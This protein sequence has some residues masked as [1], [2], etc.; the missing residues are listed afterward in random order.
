MNGARARQA[1]SAAGVRAARARPVRGDCTADSAGA[2]ADSYADWIGLAAQICAVAPSAVTVFDAEHRALGANERQAQPSPSRTRS[3]AFIEDLTTEPAAPTPQP[4]RLPAA[5]RVHLRLRLAAPTGETLGS[6]EILNV[7]PRRLSA[8]ARRALVAL[9]R[10]AGAWLSMQAAEDDLRTR[11]QQ[12]RAREIAGRARAKLQAALDETQRLQTLERIARSLSHELAMPLRMIA[13]GL[14][15]AE[16]ASR[17]LLDDTGRVPVEE[18]AFITDRLPQSF[19][20]CR[21]ALA[22]IESTVSLEASPLATV[23]A[24]DLSRCLSGCLAG[25]A[26]RTAAVADL[27]CALEPV[28]AVPGDAAALRRVFESLLGTATEAVKASGRRGCIRVRSRRHGDAVEIRI[29]DNGTGFDAAT[30][31]RVFE[32]LFTATLAE[33][34]AQPNLFRAHATIVGQHGGSLVLDS[35]PGLGS[36]FTVRL[37]LNRPLQEDRLPGVLQP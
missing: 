23:E 7:R 10:Q 22:Q 33:R 14:R 34:P 9:Q 30:C 17:T 18:Q 25:C 26:E 16:S 35:M 11:Q 32:P 19:L 3:L 4:G 21:R 27:D 15:F 20:D 36:R 6:I 24:V 12:W 31:A 13:N 28:P 29:E 2:A 8:S 1:A 5:A 37:P